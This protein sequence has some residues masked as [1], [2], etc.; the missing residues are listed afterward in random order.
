MPPDAQPAVEVDDLTVLFKRRE[1]ALAAVN[2]ASFSLARGEVMTILGESGS[3]KSVTLKAMMGLLPGYAQ[4]K[5]S[6]RVA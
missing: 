1:G 6:V 2:G 3:G 4:I 5:G